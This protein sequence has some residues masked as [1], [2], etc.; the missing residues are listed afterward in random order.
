VA[1]LK[2]SLVG[3]IATVVDL[4]VL[5]LL[6]ELVGLHPGAA[7]VPALLLGVAIQFAGNKWFAFGDR[8]REL[9]SQGLRFMAV[10]AGTLALNAVLFQLLIA[11]APLPYLLARLVATAAVYLGFSY[12][13][14]ARIFG[15]PARA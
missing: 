7:N 9:L 8:R 6:V 14:W 11:I 13:L 10:E 4:A 12:P 1:F 2:S 15:Q 5:A 3:A